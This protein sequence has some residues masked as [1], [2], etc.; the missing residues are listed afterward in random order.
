[1]SADKFAAL[2]TTVRTA[3][4][5]LASHLTVRTINHPAATDFAAPPVSAALPPPPLPVD[6]ATAPCKVKQS[7]IRPLPPSAI[8][9][10]QRDAA[11]DTSSAVAS[12]HP[13]SSSSAAAAAAVDATP[14]PNKRRK[15][16]SGQLFVV[17]SLLNVKDDG[18]GRQF[19]IR[20]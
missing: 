9:S 4:I 19:L 20:W 5:D 3:K 7:A 14:R 1:L 18:N 13:A 15:K 16:Q 12:T 17:E 6:A 11:S 8:K 2:Q 10:G